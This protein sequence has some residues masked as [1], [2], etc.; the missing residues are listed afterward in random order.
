MEF[1]AA[2]AAAAVVASLLA[3]E[4]EESVKHLPGEM[5]AARSIGVSAEE[6]R[7]TA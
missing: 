6:S 7:G 5:S 4:N 2:S 3:A 1:L